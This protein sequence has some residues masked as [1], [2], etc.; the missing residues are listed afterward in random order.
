MLIRKL[1]P[2]QSCPDDGRLINAMDERYVGDGLDVDFSV[3]FSGGTRSFPDGLHEENGR[4]FL[5][6]CLFS[7]E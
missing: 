6:D 3:S 5:R 4:R 7:T 1:F 2:G